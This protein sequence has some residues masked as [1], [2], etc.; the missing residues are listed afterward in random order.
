MRSGRVCTELAHGQ[1]FSC[2]QA[3][4]PQVTIHSSEGITDA[5]GASWGD[6]LSCRKVAMD[7]RWSSSSLLRVLSVEKESCG[8]L[9]VITG[10]EAHLFCMRKSTPKGGEYHLRR[11]WERYHGN[12]A[13][14]K[15]EAPVSARDLRIPEGLLNLQDPY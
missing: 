2:R 9:E 8:A 14:K 3:R 12:R 5:V 7:S 1:H 13:Q 6:R 15:Q 4:Q 11:G 10:Q